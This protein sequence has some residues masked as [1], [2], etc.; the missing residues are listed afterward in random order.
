MRIEFQA[1]VP[2]R[3]KFRSAHAAAAVLAL[4]AAMFV[5]G[6]RLITPGFLLST[7]Q[8][9]FT[10]VR[11]GVETTAQYVDLT[12]PFNADL[13]LDSITLRGEAGAYRFPGTVA[14]GKPSIRKRRARLASP[15]FRPSREQRGPRWK[16]RV[17]METGGPSN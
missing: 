7:N 1:R 14:S 8:L 2:G 11:V 6:H 10:G 13:V 3:R 17:S 9:N 5:S 15:S 4:L 12:N 16:W